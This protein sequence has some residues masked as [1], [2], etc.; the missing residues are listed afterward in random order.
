MDLLIWW[1]ANTRTSP[2]Y[3]VLMEYLCTPG[4]VVKNHFPPYW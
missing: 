2:T 1:K 3:A 4:V